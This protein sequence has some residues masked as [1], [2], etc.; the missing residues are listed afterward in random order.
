MGRSYYRIFF[1]LKEDTQGYGAHGRRPQGRFVVEARGSG[2]KVNVFVQDLKPLIPYKCTLIKRG[3]DKSFGVCLGAVE[4]ENRSGEARFDIDAD[5]VGGSGFPI[6][7]FDTV[8]ITHKNG[9][10][11]FPLTGG[12]G[13]DGKWKT[14]LVYDVEPRPAAPEPKAAP[15]PPAP[16]ATPPDPPDPPPAAPLPKEPEIAAAAQD[17]VLPFIQLTD[18]ER[19]AL[20]VGSPHKEF[21]EAIQRVNKELNELAELAELAEPTDIE[22][23]NPVRSVV[24]EQAA[25]EEADIEPFG[26]DA[27]AWRHITMRELMMLPINLFDYEQK[28]VI[29]AAFYKHGH[30]IRQNNTIG[31]PGHFTPEDDKGH[32][33][34]GFDTF[35]ALDGALSPGVMGYWIKD[36]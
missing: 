2:G 31:I 21:A 15:P 23:E 11:V 32:K 25:D 17:D 30:L 7:D 29:A 4:I 8:A 5:S 24:H 26:K 20:G 6:E 28:A 35:R 18:E 36:L 34:L 27:G 10:I 12:D 14:N 3:G 1:V 22:E 19:E 9:R 13:D 16:P 33:R